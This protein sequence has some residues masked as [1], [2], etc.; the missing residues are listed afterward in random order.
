MEGGN[1]GKIPCSDMFI[2]QPWTRKWKRGMERIIP[3]EH[4]SHLNPS[5]Y[6]ENRK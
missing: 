5:N 6:G 4:G 1:G 3:G 2:G